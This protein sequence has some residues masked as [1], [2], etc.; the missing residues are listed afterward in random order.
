MKLEPIV[1]RRL[2]P[3]FLAVL[4]QVTPL[5]AATLTVNTSADEDLNNASC[6]LREAIVAAN[7]NADYNGCVGIAAYGSDTILFAIPG[8]GPHIINLGSALPII[9]SPIHIYGPSQPGSSQN[10]AASGTNAVI[11]V[12]IDGGGSVPSGFTISNGANGGSLIGIMVTRFARGVEV[13]GLVDGFTISGNFIGTDGQSEQGNQTGIYAA[14]FISNLVIGGPN[15]ADRNLISGNDYYGVNIIGLIGSGFDIRDNLIGTA[16]DGNTAM[17]GAVGIYFQSGG[18]NHNISG[19][20]IGGDDGIRIYDDTNGI[21]ITGNSIGVGANGS[22]DI[23]GT[24]YGIE[25]RTGAGAT[26]HHLSIGGDNP[27]LGNLIANFGNDGIQI[28]RINSADPFPYRIQML[29]NR[30][31]DNGGLGINL[32]D[33]GGGTGAGI[34]PNDIDDVDDGPNGYQNYPVISAATVNGADTSV[35]FHLDGNPSN[36]T[37]RVEFFSSSSCDASGNGEGMVFLGGENWIT[38]DGDVAHT[39]VLPATTPGH[40][41][42]MTATDGLDNTSEFSACQQVVSGSAGNTTTEG[43]PT[44]AGWLQALLAFM[45][46]MLGASGIRAK[47]AGQDRN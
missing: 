36:S 28:N 43:V 45:L 33:E 17:L 42:T 25:I 18:S 9:T 19:N 11:Q 41:I 37:Y 13:I 30:I 31:Y 47:L 24:G 29:A 38:L 6:S 7:N 40:F 4:M 20:V 39:S 12:G 46:M 27:S 26:P 32:L 1:R 34:N 44:L 2:I 23:G 8:A 14:D 15:L 21:T 35:T 3:I 16:A 10:T 22:S 5:S